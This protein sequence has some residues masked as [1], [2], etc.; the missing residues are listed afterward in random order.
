MS[1]AFGLFA[2]GFETTSTT[3]SFCLYELA[4]KKN[5]QDRVREEIK[6]TKIKCNGVID[7]EFLTNL[8]YL[9]MV[10]AGIYFKI[11]KMYTII[12]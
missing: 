1:N 6:L 11:Y 9:D 7:N 4:L 10:I 3:L 2:A 8:N 5:I 12:V